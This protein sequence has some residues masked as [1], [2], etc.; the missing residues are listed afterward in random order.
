MGDEDE[1]IENESTKNQKL[2]DDIFNIVNCFMNRIK[3]F[4]FVFKYKVDKLK[5]QLKKISFDEI[6][7]QMLNLKTARIDSRVIF[8]KEELKTGL[9]TI[10]VKKIRDLLKSQIEDV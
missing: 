6:R 9:F 7:K 3:D 10:N 8:F 1:F 5:E 4:D 2:I